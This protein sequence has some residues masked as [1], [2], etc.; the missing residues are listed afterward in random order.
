MYYRRV[1]VCDEDEDKSR[2]KV[3]CAKTSVRGL[4][5]NDIC[6]QYIRGIVVF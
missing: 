6:P 3:T 1:V 2:E 5:G 4:S